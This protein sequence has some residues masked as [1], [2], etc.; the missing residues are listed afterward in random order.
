MSTTTSKAYRIM[1]CPFFNKTCM[2]FSSVGWRL[3]ETVNLS[4]NNITGDIEDT[5][6]RTGKNTERV[7]SRNV[8]PVSLT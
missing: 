4:R 2:L 5:S 6:L 7:T 3:N 1:K 8:D